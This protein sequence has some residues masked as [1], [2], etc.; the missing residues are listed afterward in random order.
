MSIHMSMSP[1]SLAEAVP[2]LYSD[3]ELAGNCINECLHKCQ[4]GKGEEMWGS[5]E[6]TETAVTSVAEWCSIHQ[7]SCF[8]LG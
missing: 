6:R 4:R 7:W 2:A 8:S 3:R 5:E 1:L